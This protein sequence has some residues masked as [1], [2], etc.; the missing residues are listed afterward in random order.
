MGIQLFR[1]RKGLSVLLGLAILAGCGG[2]DS[3]A[4]VT[5]QNQLSAR[6][7]QEDQESRQVRQELATGDFFDCGG[8]V[9][10]NKRSLCAFA[11]NMQSSYY[12]NVVSGPAKVNGY[13]PADKKD[14]RVFCTG[15]VPHRCTGFKDDGQAW[16]PLKGALIFFSP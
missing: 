2:S 15:T 5:A 16:K 11:K 8:R 10:V 4:G 12:G 7:K 9:F 13:H 14:Y 1:S 3:S 6:E